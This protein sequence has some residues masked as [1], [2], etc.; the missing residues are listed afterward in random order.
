MRN[1]ISKY[2]GEFAH[3]VLTLAELQAQLLVADLRHC[4]HKLFVPGLVLLVGVALALACFPFALIV[5]AL[6]IKETVG[7]TYA[8][9]FLIVLGLGIVTGASLCTFSW[10]QIRKHTAVLSRSQQ[11]LVRNVLWIKKVLERSRIKRGNSFDNSWRT[12]S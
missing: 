10:I 12:D 6:C 9:S 11:E 7:T 1:R 4:R 3:N 5:L 2:V 8:A